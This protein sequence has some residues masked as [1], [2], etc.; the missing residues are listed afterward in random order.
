M[1]GGRL[2]R[3]RRAAAGPAAEAAGGEP[4][5]RPRAPPP[6]GAGCA[7]RSALRGGDGVGLDLGEPRRGARR[8]EAP[9]HGVGP[10]PGTTTC[11]LPELGR[12]DRGQVHPRKRP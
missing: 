2:G 9:E 3:R 10:H 1:G 12:K 5:R 11:D 4:R 6:R 8:R 7:D